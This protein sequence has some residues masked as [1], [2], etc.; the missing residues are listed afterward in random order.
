[1]EKIQT[2]I[3]VI[4]PIYQVEEYIEECLESL[5]RQG[6]VNL[7]VIMVDDG[8]TDASGAIA[9]RYAHT[10]AYFHYYYIQ[11]DGLGHARNYGTAL[12]HGKYLA[13]LDSDDVLA[14]GTYERLFQLAEKQG[15]DLT[16]FHVARFHTTKT[17]SSRL[18]CLAFQNLERDTYGLHHP[19]LVY[20]TVVCN[21][22]ILRSFYLE[23]QFVFPEHRLYEDMLLSISMYYYAKRI[24]ISHEIGYFWR[25]RDGAEKSITQRTSMGLTNLQ[26]RLTAIDA[27]NQFLDQNA[28]GE[29]AA[30]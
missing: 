13:F 16:V 5:L 23:H 17:W 9:K 7:E 29:P 14:D 2:D 15:N 25:E 22:L 19:D 12:A 28:A 27:V 18:H 24:S 6:N 10:Y 1:M 20:D 4:V 26:D 11:N 8:S 30:I 3:S 21:K